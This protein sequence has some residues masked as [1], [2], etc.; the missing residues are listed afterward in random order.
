MK[1]RQI[2]GIPFFSS[3]ITIIVDVRDRCSISLI[4]MQELERIF[5]GFDIQLVTVFSAKIWKKLFGLRFTYL[6][7]FFNR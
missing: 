7:S 3:F 5:A 4:V 6:V 2:S 1:S